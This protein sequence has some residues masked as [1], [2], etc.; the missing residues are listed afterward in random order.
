[1]MTKA[2]Q[3]NPMKPKAAPIIRLNAAINIIPIISFS[4][5]ICQ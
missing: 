2:N 1:M 3:E 4:P 5:N